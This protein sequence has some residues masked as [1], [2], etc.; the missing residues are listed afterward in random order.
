MSV[1]FKFTSK[2][3]GLDMHDIAVSAIYVAMVAAFPNQHMMVE[4][5]LNPVPLI[6]TF[7]PPVVGPSLGEISS[8]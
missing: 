4:C 3:V 5:S 7:V 1:A 6:V 2:N 8:K